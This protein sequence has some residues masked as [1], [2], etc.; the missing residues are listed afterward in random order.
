M[1][2]C[3][4][5]S[6]CR[7]F[8]PFTESWPKCWIIS[9]AAL[10]IHVIRKNSTPLWKPSSTFFDSSCSHGFFIWGGF[11]SE[12]AFGKNFLQ[13]G[14]KIT[15]ELVLDLMMQMKNKKNWYSRNS[16]FVQIHGANG[17]PFGALRIKVIISRVCWIKELTGN[18]LQRASF[19]HE[20]NWTYKWNCYSGT[21]C[22]WCKACRALSFAS[23]N[24]NLCLFNRFYGKSEDGGQFLD[25]IRTLFLSISNLMD[26]PLDEGVKI[27]A[28]LTTHS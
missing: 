1:Q 8:S 7:I 5:V 16:V 20:I 19:C 3:V 2:L 23:K 17:F 4:I 27:K 26:R 15:I 18:L 24:V 22:H 12:H 11:R 21:S 14:W 6:V 10:R 25:S 13:A 28:G 9:W